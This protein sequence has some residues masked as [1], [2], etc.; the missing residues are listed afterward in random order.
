[1]KKIAIC[2]LFHHNYN[3]GGILQAYALSHVIKCLGN[4]VK[5]VDYDDKVN[6]NPV[7]PTICSRLSQY[8]MTEIIKKISSIVVSK[9]NGSVKSKLQARISLFNEFIEQY[10]EKT[11]L[12][13]DADVENLARNFDV[14]VC[15]SDQVWNPNSLTKLYLLDFN[16]PTRVKRVSYAAS[17][18]RNALSDRE[19][20]IMVPAINKFDHVSVREITAE[21]IL[22]KLG[23][24]NI[25]TVLDPTLLLSSQDW[26]NVS[27]ARI[28]QEPYVLVYSFSECKF[29]SQLIKVYQKRGIGVYF[30]PFAKQEYNKF[31]SKR[32]GMKPLFDI[33]P[34]EFL[35]LFKYAEA[36]YTDSFHGTVFSII[37][38]KNVVVYER[39]GNGH[40]SKNSRLHD[41]LSTF[42][43]NECM[44]Y[45][46]DCD[47]LP[48][49]VDYDVVYGTINKLRRASLEWLQQAINE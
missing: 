9:A 35:S 28:I 26:D 34:S 7:Y 12:V 10:F 25:S 44:K 23:V 8:T 38:Q 37:Y 16:L 43:M 5:I 18:S 41:L 20:S 49:I 14:F 32:N 11:S 2:T 46:T 47:I 33:G 30:I 48:S 6:T 4:D 21:N 19:K 31:D 45:E 15:G 42:G 13:G 36:I 17:I 24:K 1:M 40:T 3:Y 39:D 29:S 27:C 22:K